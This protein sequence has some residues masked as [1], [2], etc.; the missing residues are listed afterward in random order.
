MRGGRWAIGIVAVF[1]LAACASTAPA[2]RHAPVA[3][4]AKQRSTS[5][6]D[7]CMYSVNAMT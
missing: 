6:Y 3:P 5:R 1:T 7:T 4:T 2:A